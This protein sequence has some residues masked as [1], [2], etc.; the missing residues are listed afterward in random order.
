[1]KTVVPRNLIL[2]LA[3]LSLAACSLIAQ[4]DQVAYEHATNAKVDTL[5]LM[6]KATGSYSDHQKEIGA[7]V[8]VINKR[9]WKSDAEVIGTFKL[10]VRI[11]K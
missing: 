7:L 10:A 4:Y 6:D 8:I 1:M 11:L 9:A 2:S 3:L 5:A